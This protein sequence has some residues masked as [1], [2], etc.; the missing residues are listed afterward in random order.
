MIRPSAP[1]VIHGEAF[2]KVC[3]VLNTVHHVR[4]IDKDL[5]VPAILWDYRTMCKNLTAQALPTLKYEEGVII[6]IGHV[7]A[8]THVAT[9][10][11][12]MVCEA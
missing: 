3:K 1:N 12:T 7:K 2:D 6:P 4:C 11:D 8:S 5:H 10:I 9:P